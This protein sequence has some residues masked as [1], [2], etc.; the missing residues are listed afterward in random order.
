MANAEVVSRTKGRRVVLIAGL[1]LALMGGLGLTYLGT[2]TDWNLN[3]A[4]GPKAAAE[5]APA[6]A[7]AKRSE[8][9]V[10]PPSFDVVSVDERGKFVAAGR[11]EAGWTIQLRSKSQVLGETKVDENSEWV[12][13]PE[14]PLSPGEHSLSLIAVDPSGQRHVAGDRDSRVTV[15]QRREIAQPGVTPA[16]KDQSSQVAA[17][18]PDFAL[19]QSVGQNAGKEGCVSAV[20]KSGDTLWGIAHH[21]Y[22]SGTKY[23]KIFR[24]NHSLIRKPGLIYPDQRLTV[25]R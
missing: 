13:T 5:K 1:L 6:K 21:C 12:L 23:T 14:A 10:L 7:D 17:R 15:A 4:S 9:G 2:Q 8:A 16:L 11:S 19:T 22:G 20:V 3:A 18:S 24:S 25:P